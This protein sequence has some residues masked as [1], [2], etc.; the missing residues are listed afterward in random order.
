[1]KC[2]EKIVKAKLIKYIGCQQDPLQFAYT[3]NR[4]TLDPTVLIVHDVLKFLDSPN[5]KHNSHFV[6]ILFIDF[7]SAFNTLQIHIML[8]RLIKLQVNPNIVLWIYS[9]L[10]HRQQYVKFNDTISEIVYTETG[11]PQGCVLS[12]LLFTLYTNNCRS[13][14]SSCKVY[15]YADDTAL[16]GFCNNTDNEYQLEVQSFVTWCR[17]N[18]LLLNVQKTKEIVID[19]RRTPQ[20]HNDL[21]I[22]DENV[23]R[24]SEYKYL[25]TIINDKLNFE[26]NINTIYKKANSRMFFVRKLY[27]LQVDN[28]IVELFYRSVVESVITFGIAAWYGNCSQTSRNKLTKVIKYAKRLNIENVKTLQ[29]LYEKSTLQKAKAIRSEKEHPLYNCYQTLRSGRRLQA[30]Y[31]RTARY[32]RSFVPASIRLINNL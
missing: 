13:N 1:M 17:E 5:S 21:I 7:S 30:E 23:E 20:V 3:K 16:V 4:S 32:N 8:D 6:K 10:S 22:N 19:F 29:E 31:T 2:L 28:K 9:F 15:K 27:N 18:Y 11:A 14:S 25:G 26:E 24:V 12:P